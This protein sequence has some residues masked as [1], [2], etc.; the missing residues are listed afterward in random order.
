MATLM[1]V[2]RKAFTKGVG[3][4]KLSS[5][6]RVEQRES[7]LNVRLPKPVWPGPGDDLVEPRGKPVTALRLCRQLAFQVDADPNGVANDVERFGEETAAAYVRAVLARLVAAVGKP[8]TSLPDVRELRRRARAL[9]L[10]CRAVAG[11]TL[12]DTVKDL[13]DASV[14]KVVLEPRWP[15]QRALVL[16]LTSKG[17]WVEELE[18][19]FVI[20]WVPV[21]GLSVR[22][23]AARRLYLHNADA[24]YLYE[25]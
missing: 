14:E 25:R 4:S 5:V 12:Y 16:S 21:A 13:S 7:A 8:D 1:P 15:D 23:E 10:P 18:P 3:A 17:P 11:P 20:E 6:L 22:L 9:G 19:L 24:C 2:I